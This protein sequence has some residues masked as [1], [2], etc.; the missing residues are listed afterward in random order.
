MEQNKSSCSNAKTVEALDILG[1]AKPYGDNVKRILDRDL[2]KDYVPKHD[3][4]M[5]Q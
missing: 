1:A 2:D 4:K 5:Y 3:S